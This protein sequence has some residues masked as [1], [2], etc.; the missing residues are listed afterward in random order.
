MNNTLAHLMSKYG[1]A[2]R[3]KVSLKK[4]MREFIDKIGPCNSIKNM[5]PDH[6][7]VFNKHIERHPNF[8][9]KIGYDDIVI[10]KKS[11]RSNLTVYITLDGKLD[12][13]GIMT[14]CVDGRPTS[15]NKNLYKAMRSA[16]LDQT[17]KYRQ[18]NIKKCSQC[19]SS[20]VPLDIHHEGIDFKD[21]ANAFLEE[22]ELQIPEQFDCPPDGGKCFKEEDGAFAYEWEDY[23]RKNA[24][25][26]FLCE[27]CHNMTHTLKK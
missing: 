27:K 24:T 15:R 6:Y 26:T 25:L 16:I 14:K 12:A 18:N 5:Y 1:E 9:K 22:V 2:T 8:E 17:D 21:L 13:I 23:H 20:S 19:G 10:C 4:F 3:T 7:V 11:N